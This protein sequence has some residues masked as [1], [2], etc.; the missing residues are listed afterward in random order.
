LNSCAKG[1][2]EWYEALGKVNSTVL[3]LIDKYPELLQIEG[4][5]TRDANGVLTLS[6][7]AR[8]YVLD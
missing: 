2:D 1:T 3:A 8:Q 5:L 7:K 4:A 6:E